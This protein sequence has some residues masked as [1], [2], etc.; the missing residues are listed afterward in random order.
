MGKREN[1]KRKLK[2][3]DRRRQRRPVPPATTVAPATNK[4]ALDVTGLIAT[5]I[6]QHAE[7]ASDGLSDSAV[8]AAMR[9][10]LKGTSPSAEPSR[11]L[12]E[13]FEQVSLR[14]EVDTRRFRSALSRMLDLAISSR[15]SKNQTAFLGYLSVLMR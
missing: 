14:S 1:L 2:A 11:S 5:E 6:L 4:S 7:S 10:F 12:Y 9:S 8:V 13:R 3:A 15:D